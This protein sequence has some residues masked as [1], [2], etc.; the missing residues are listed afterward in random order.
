MD[1]GWYEPSSRGE[2]GVGVREGMGPGEG[3]Q[4]PAS[5]P[6]PLGD[7]PAPS[8]FQPLL[9]AGRKLLCA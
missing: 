4:T 6:Q 8:G 9:I 5:A 1:G 3:P 2:Q 7:S